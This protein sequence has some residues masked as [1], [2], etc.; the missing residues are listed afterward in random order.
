MKITQGKKIYNTIKKLFPIN[1]SLTGIGNR[2]S[3]NILNSVCK[4]LDILEFKSGT[5][6][7]DWI[8]PDEWNVKNA[9]IKCDNKKI[10]DFKKNNLHLVSYSMPI[11]KLISYEELNKHLYSVN[12]KPNAIPYVTSYYKKNW[13]FCIEHKKRLKLNKK[14][15][16]HVFIVSKF[17]KD[18][19]M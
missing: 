3:L 14:K 5:K 2:V 6:V 1:R 16:Y 4:N 11:N 9:Y 7:Y 15:K 10:L 17:K 13:G 8:I 19:S 18:G 12:D